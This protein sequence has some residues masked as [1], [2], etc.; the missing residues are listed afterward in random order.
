[1]IWVER[2]R[3]EF[4]SAHRE[5]PDDVNVSV[6]LVDCL[7]SLADAQRGNNNFDA[8]LHASEQA[9]ALNEEI[10][11]AHPE[12]PYY[13]E[14]LA[15]SL[16]SL[17]DR[18]TL[19][20]LPARAAIARAVG[21]Y[22][23]LVRSYPGVSRFRTELIRAL[24]GLAFLARQERDDAMSVE[25]TRR[26]VSLCGLLTVDLAD[27]SAALVADSQLALAMASFDMG[28]TD[29]AVEA[30]Q[31]AA[32][33]AAHRAA[34]RAGDLQLRVYSG[35]A[36]PRHELAGGEE[37]DRRPRDARAFSR[38]PSRLSQQA[39]LPHRPRHRQPARPSGLPAP[40][41]GPGIPAES[42]GEIVG[43]GSSRPPD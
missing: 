42:L 35:A 6:R 32:N 21:R 16:K 18:Q 14:S 12:T 27:G 40:V 3:Q 15:R 30:M 43:G 23:D 25:A 8:M 20:K 9:C 41:H 2:A 24:L 26:A 37:S 19:A 38:H 1:M 5:S 22:Q 13:T 29:E 4:E 7:N 39:D 10:A 28:H 36:E 34:E 17:S 33:H 31:A 11:N